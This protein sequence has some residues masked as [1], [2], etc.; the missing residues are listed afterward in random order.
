M[1]P[2]IT[3]HLLSVSKINFDNDMCLE[4]WRNHC[5][6]KSLQGKTLLQGQVR[7]GLY[8]VPSSPSKSL[9]QPFPPM[10]L[11]SLREPPSMVDKSV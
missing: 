2:H 5:S 6:V 9:H 11:T 4:F 7:N 10:A 3:K 1:V 8:R